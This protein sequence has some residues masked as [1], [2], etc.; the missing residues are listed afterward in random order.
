MFAA[1]AEVAA[2]LEHDRK[3]IGRD[4]PTR[5]ITNDITTAGKNLVARYA[6]RM[7]VENE[8]DAYIGG[9]TSTRSP[10]AFRSTSTWTP[11]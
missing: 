5:L 7:M 3:H 9:F 10:A 1:P 2:V 6:E 8:L 4:G 11:R